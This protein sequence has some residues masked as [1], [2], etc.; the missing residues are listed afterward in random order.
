MQD[1]QQGTVTKADAQ[2]WMNEALSAF[3]EIDGEEPL[4]PGARN[5]FRYELFPKFKSMVEGLFRHELYTEVRDLCRLL[6]CFH[7]VILENGP[8]GEGHMLQLEDL[9]EKFQSWKP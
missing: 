1:E 9:P 2:D 5:V 6:D 4:K 8:F 7:G 3:E